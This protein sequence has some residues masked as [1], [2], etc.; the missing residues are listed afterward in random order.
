[1]FNCPQ[2]PCTWDSQ[3]FVKI[4]TSIPKHLPI[5]DSTIWVPCSHTEKKKNPLWGFWGSGV[6]FESQCYHTRGLLARE[7][8]KSP[9][10]LISAQHERPELT[11]STLASWFCSL[12]PV[13]S[14][15]KLW[16]DIETCSCAAAGLASMTTGSTSVVWAASFQVRKAGDYS[17]SPV[18]AANSPSSLPC[19]DRSIWTQLEEHHWVCYS[20]S[21]VQHR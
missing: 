21:A 17:S 7:Q 19:Q 4:H 13:M 20:L 15:L 6:T 16:P 14:P 1:M 3:T 18:T 9:A 10:P 8:S 12:I 2:F 11:H 5:S